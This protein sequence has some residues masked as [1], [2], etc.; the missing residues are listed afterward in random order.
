LPASDPATEEGRKLV[1]KFVAGVREPGGKDVA[2]SN[3][4]LV[5]V[6]FAIAAKMLT[7]KILGGWS[8][9]ANSRM[10]GYPIGE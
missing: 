6:A 10:S 9:W 2:L 3:E 1:A 8:K 5:T 7:R 4:E